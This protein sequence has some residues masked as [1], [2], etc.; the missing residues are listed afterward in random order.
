[1]IARDVFSTI[2]AGLFVSVF[3]SACSSKG[4]STPRSAEPLSQQATADAGPRE[5]TCNPEF[6]G[7]PGGSTP[8]CTAAG[9]CGVLAGKECV[10][11]T[12]APCEDAISFGAC[13]SGYV[14]PGTIT[15]CFATKE[16][17]CRCACK[18]G[19]YVTC[20]A[21]AAGLQ[22]LSPDVTCR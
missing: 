13:K 15:P 2:V 9:A 3:V 19:T 4:G 22:P 7:H 20:D 5:T 21:P 1:M 18:N 12:A 16:A 10:T 11:A 17:A 8:C 14:V 6:C